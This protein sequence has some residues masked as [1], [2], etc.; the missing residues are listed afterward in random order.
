M[1]KTLTCTCG[2]PGSSSPTSATHA[3]PPALLIPYNNSSAPPAASA[4]TRSTS[5]TSS[6]SRWMKPHPGKLYQLRFNMIRF[7]LL[8][9]VPPGRGLPYL[10][11]RL[12]QEQGNVK[13][14]WSSGPSFVIGS[15][16]CVGGG[17][18][19]HR[20]CGWC[21]R[22]GDLCAPDDPCVQKLMLKFELQHRGLRQASP[23][24]AMLRSGRRR[25]VKKEKR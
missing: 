15:L 14:S 21:H 10:H 2:P 1:A 22:M 5:M 23:L 6:A 3:G 18:S 4:P 8:P 25:E 11:Q 7:N 13:V 12:K 19:Q 24:P 17:G 9:L 20:A 16:W